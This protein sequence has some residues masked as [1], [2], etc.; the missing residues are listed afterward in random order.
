MKKLE[1]EAFKSSKSRF[2][3]EP[4]MA[5]TM[6]DMMQNSRLTLEQAYNHL[7]TESAKYPDRYSEKELRQAYEY[8]NSNNRSA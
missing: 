5:R 1:E 4:A 3:T 2:K 8:L 6:Q 7:M